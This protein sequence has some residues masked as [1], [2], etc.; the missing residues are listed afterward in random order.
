M[1]HVRRIVIDEMQSRLLDLF[2]ILELFDALCGLA[3][4]NYP[5]DDGLLLVKVCNGKVKR[6]TIDKKRESPQRSG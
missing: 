5:R 2:M 6:D 3:R 1:S 4:D